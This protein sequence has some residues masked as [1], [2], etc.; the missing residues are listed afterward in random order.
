MT[1]KKHFYDQA[2]TFVASR[3]SS[4]CNTWL[5]EILRVTRVSL[6]DNMASGK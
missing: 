1:R 6:L 4:T 3:K 5:F 2:F